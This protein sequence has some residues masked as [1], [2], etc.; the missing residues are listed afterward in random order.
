[1]SNSQSHINLGELSKALSQSII[2]Y[3]PTRVDYTVSESEL[4]LLENYGNNIWK[5]VFIATLSL[6]I[7]TLINGVISYNKLQPNANLTL[8]IFINFIVGISCLI[9]AI[10]FFFV[11]RKYSKKFSNIISNIKQKPQF[12]LPTG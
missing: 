9:V 6:G 4:I 1:M 5:D 2:H 8:E 12:Q 7:P 10:V 11:W 3:N